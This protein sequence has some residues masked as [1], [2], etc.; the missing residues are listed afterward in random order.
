MTDA[1]LDTIRERNRPED[2]AT[3]ISRLIELVCDAAYKNA[4]R[5]GALPWKAW[6]STL[7]YSD[8]A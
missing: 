3:D 2:W 7:T 8:S 5:C 4:E 6:A 1:E